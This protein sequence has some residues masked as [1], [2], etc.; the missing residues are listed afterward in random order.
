M[1]IQ[2]RFKKKQ[3]KI[4][5]SEKYWIVI[6]EYIDN[7]VKVVLKNKNR[8]FSYMRNNILK[9]KYYYVHCFNTELS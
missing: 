1:F 4:L 9:A 3:G 5:T 8:W 6:E 7:I 2:V